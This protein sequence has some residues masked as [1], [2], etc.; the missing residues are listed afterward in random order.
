MIIICV[1]L[2]R[3]DPAAEYDAMKRKDLDLKDSAM[4]REN[5]PC[6]CKSKNCFSSVVNA[7]PKTAIFTEADH[8]F[9]PSTLSV[10]LPVTKQLLSHA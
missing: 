5:R 6:L 7:I 3:R 4:T 2:H 1:V 8:F 10:F 9:L